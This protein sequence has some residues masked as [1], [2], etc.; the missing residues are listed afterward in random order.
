MPAAFVPAGGKPQLRFTVPSWVIPGTYLENLR[1]LADKPEIRGVEL[2]FFLY[3]GEIRAELESEWQG[4]REY[5]DRFVYTAHLPDLLRPDHWELVERLSPLVRHF[6]VHPGPVEGAKAQAELLRSWTERLRNRA[7]TPS[8]PP[9]PASKSP[10][11]IENTHPGRLP[12]LLPHLDA[13]IGLCM[14]TGHLLL[15]GQN[16]A[17]F[18]RRY[19]DRVGE[20]HLHGLDREKAARDGRLPDHRP[21]RAEDP[22]LAELVPLLADFPGPVNL[23]VFSWEE[24][25]ESIATLK[26]LFVKQPNEY[27]RSE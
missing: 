13:D 7:D 21:L 3:N 11:L 5:G 17:D 20:V 9:V 16:P 22:W 19:G 14:D 2:L 15:E 25:Q 12:A 26:T 10:F 6:I 23:E 4:I 18:L 24:V 8:V 1:F 27:P